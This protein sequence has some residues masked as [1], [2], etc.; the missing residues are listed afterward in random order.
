MSK[1]KLQKKVKRLKGEISFL[2]SVLSSKFLS[3][4]SIFDCTTFRN[5]VAPVTENQNPVR[6]SRSVDAFPPVGT[7][8][9]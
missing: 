5:S 7:G 1:K 3:S 2:K 4:V 8:K 6:N 9:A